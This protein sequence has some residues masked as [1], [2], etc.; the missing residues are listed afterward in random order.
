MDHLLV[1]PV[2]PFEIAAS[3]IWANGLIIAIAVSLSLIIV[4]RTLLGVPIA[5]SIPLFLAGTALCDCDWHLPRDR[6]PLDAAAR[7]A[8]HHADRD[9]DEHIVRQQHAA[10]E[11]AAMARSHHAGVALYTLRLFRTGDPLS[12]YWP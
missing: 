1:M 5:G 2:S 12:R 11:H 8:F 7:V 3:K 10:R 4:V 9:A 6:R